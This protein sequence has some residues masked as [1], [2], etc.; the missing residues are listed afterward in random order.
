MCDVFRDQRVMNMMNIP[1]GYRD[2]R[3]RADG[4]ETII[5]DQSR[6]RVVLE[7]K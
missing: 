5:V 6:I 2:E 4:S 3:K 1:E 7:H